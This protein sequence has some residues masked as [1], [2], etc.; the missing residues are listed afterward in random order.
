MAQPR[1]VVDFKQVD[2]DL[3]FNPILGDFEFVPSDNQHILDILRSYPGY[4]KRV[5]GIGAGIGSLLKAK[6]NVVT[7]ENKTKTQLESDSY[8]VG[9]PVLSVD[10][11]GR[12]IISP[13]AERL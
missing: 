8:Q 11:N 13:K 2:D 7:V 1:P 4:W 3:Y 10:R 6:I 12:A 9:R 5:P